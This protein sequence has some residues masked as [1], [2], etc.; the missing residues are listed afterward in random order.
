[1][2]TEDF[3][4]DNAQESADYQRNLGLQVVSGLS[5]ELENVIKASLID[6]KNLSSAVMKLS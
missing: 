3:V 5:N 4:E 2:Q 1:M 6:G